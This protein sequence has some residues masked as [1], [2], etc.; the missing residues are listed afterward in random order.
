LCTVIATGKYFIHIPQMAAQ[1]TLVDDSTDLH[2]IFVVTYLRG[3]ER[4]RYAL[5][6]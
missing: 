1:C 3:Q 6:A 2:L 4:R 5:N